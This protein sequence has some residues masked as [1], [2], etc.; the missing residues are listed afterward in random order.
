MGRPSKLTPDLQARLVEIF[1][2]GQT[3]IET[4]CDYVG[5]GTTTYHRWMQENREFRDAIQK[6]RAEAVT[7]YL[8][9]IRKAANSGQWQ[10]AAWWLERVLP[11]Q[12]G[13]KSQVEV[14]TPD[15]IERE[16]A[17]LEAE[18]ADNDA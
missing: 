13:R 10:A 1:Q 7:G 12:Y 4:A 18:L 3:S 5:I 8:A 6:A 15:V 17:R 11:A 9:V 2:I 16:I 14:L